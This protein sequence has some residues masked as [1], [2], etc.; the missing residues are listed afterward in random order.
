MNYFKLLKYVNKIWCLSKPKLED[1]LKPLTP[2]PSPGKW[3]KFGQVRL[4]KVVPLTS[5]L[6][7]FCLEESNQLRAR[8]FPPENAFVDRHE[9]LKCY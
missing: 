7:E 4:E 6:K 5:N 9:Y 3:M 1:N 8:F 2:D